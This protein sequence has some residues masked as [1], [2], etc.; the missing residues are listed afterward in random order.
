MG[1]AVLLVVALAAAAGLALGGVARRLWAFAGAA[2]M[3]G[4]TGYAWQGAPTYAGHPVAAQAELRDIDPGIAELRGAM[5]GRYNGEQAFAGAADALVRSGATEAAVRLLIGA[6]GSYPQNA[7][8][9][10]RLGDA[11][12][13]HDQAVSPAALFAFRRAAQLAPASAG[14]WFFLGLAQVR[15]GDFAGARGS[16]A[17]ALALSP[18]GAEYRGAVA[19]RLALLDRYLA[20]M[21]AQRGQ[22]G[23]AGR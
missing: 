9:W 6:T 3:L 17:R 19:E 2:L 1:W 12:A 10:T 14:P 22:G 7:A 20:Y 15:V 23:P 11:L 13:E 5:F 16:W 4:A 21:A 8:L 18:D